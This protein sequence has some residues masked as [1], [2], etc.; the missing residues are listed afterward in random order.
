MYHAAGGRVKNRAPMSDAER[1]EAAFWAAFLR[2]RNVDAGTAADGAVAVAG[3]YALCV[4]GTML[5][6]AVGAGS[7]RPLRSDDLEV[8][9]GFYAARH[10]PARF[11]LDAD[12]LARDEALLCRRGYFDEGLELAVL[13]AQARAGNGGDR[14]I[15]VRTT[16]DRRAWSELLSLAVA[17]Q[18]P[19]PELRRRSA[20]LSAAAGSILVTATLDGADIGVGA[21]GI[22]G[23]SA[24]LFSGAVLPAFRGRGVH[25]ALVAARVGLA[26]ERG[27]AR[28]ILKAPPGSPAQRSAERHG[29]TQTGLRRR[30]ARPAG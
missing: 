27:A 19:D 8:V 17:E 22:S 26:H 13:E 28:V 25:S 3:G 5:E 29:F 14:G 9:E 6:Y 2:N 23:E 20:Q 4:V 16:T 7:T 24:L 11:E 18:I 12:A 1:A 30:M 15:T 10:L 21:L